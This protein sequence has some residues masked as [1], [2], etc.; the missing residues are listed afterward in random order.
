MVVEYM[1]GV[2]K[3]TQSQAQVAFQVYNEAREL[4]EGNAEGLYACPEDDDHD[5]L[6]E[7]IV[8]ARD[9]LFEAQLSARA[10]VLVAGLDLLDAIEAVNLERDD[11]PRIVTPTGGDL[12]AIAGA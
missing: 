1:A 7:G 3:Q 6:R 10:D 4:L 8:E 9:T 12:Q 5:T 2:L 11:P